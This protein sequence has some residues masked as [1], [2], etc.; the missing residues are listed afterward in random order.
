[1]NKYIYSDVVAGNIVSG[2][3]IILILFIH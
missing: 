2:D 3:I 1:L